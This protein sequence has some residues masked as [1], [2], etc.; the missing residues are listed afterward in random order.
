MTSQP[1]KETESQIEKHLVQACI[2]NGMQCIKY[3]NPSASGY[4]DRLILA[5]HGRA[6]WVELKAP[7]QRPREL[8]VERLHQLARLGFSTYAI[9]CTAAA[10]LLVL[11]LVGIV[12]DMH[13]LSKGL[14]I[15][16]DS[17][18]LTTIYQATK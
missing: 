9:D 18:G 16:T 1:R 3:S 13:K 7:R 12:P 6:I 14:H 2:I 10:Q 15:A 5:P 8:Q 4:P 17:E 11:H